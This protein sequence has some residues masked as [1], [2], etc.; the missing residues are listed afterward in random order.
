M[1]CA[2]ENGVVCR[3]CRDDDERLERDDVRV[4]PW[5]ESTEPVV[6]DPEAWR[7]VA[8]AGR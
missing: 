5:E 6:R 8:K 4:S 1:M 3:R 7:A 2:C